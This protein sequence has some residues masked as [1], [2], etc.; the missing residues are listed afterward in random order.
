[1]KK[2]RLFAVAAAMGMFASTVAAAEPVVSTN[3]VA[4]WGSVDEIIKVDVGDK[5]VAPAATVKVIKE[6]RTTDA[7]EAGSID[8]LGMDVDEECE[9]DDNG[10]GYTD[11]QVYFNGTEPG[12][13]ATKLAAIEEYLVDN[14]LVLAPNAAEVEEQYYAKYD[15]KFFAD[16]E[17]VYAYLEEKGLIESVYDE[18]GELTNI[19]I[20]QIEVTDKKGNVLSNARYNYTVGNTR[21]ADEDAMIAV[22]DALVDGKTIGKAEELKNYTKKAKENKLG[23]YY[24]DSKD[25]VQPI[26][27]GS[28]V[29]VSDYKGDLVVEKVFAP[30]DG[31][32]E[33][34]ATG[35][36]HAG[37]EGTTATVKGT[38]DKVTVYETD[39]YKEVTKVATLSQST[40]AQYS[41]FAKMIWDE[42]VGSFVKTTD[43]YSAV[44]EEVKGYWYANE[45]E[46][47]Y[48]EDGEKESETK[49]KTFTAADLAINVPAFGLEEV[50]FLPENTSGKYV[51]QV[52]SVAG[53]NEKESKITLTNTNG[54]EIVVDAVEVDD[55]LYPA[56]D[57]MEELVKVASKLPEYA[58]LGTKFG[59]TNKVEGIAKD[60]GTVKSADYVTWY[61][62]TKALNDNPWS[63]YS[64]DYLPKSEL[65]GPASEACTYVIEE[66]SVEVDAVI[67][68]DAD[69]VDTS[70][71]GVK[72][73]TLTAKVGEE[74]VSTKEVKVVV[75][76]KYERT[77]V[78][79][80]V[81]VLKAFHLNGNL[82]AEYH[83]DWAAKTYSATFYQQDGVTVGSTANG[84]L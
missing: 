42:E 75:A 58:D 38:E 50:E 83:Y 31:E 45:Y 48:D 16:W 77:Y 29:I 28:V 66:E 69:A 9:A 6:T 14:H 74:V 68:S 73:L 27:L 64:V 56:F 39:K 22:V 3:Y 12:Y 1:M 18:D 34:V 11:V 51:L 76:P 47:E 13:Y 78:N 8:N 44:S 62:A 59:D 65:R 20:N 37:W 82:Y 36:T 79:G 60:A 57:T 23:F 52:G 46:V 25:K 2:V 24:V 63:G 10:D 15:N 4:T 72:T 67:S 7:D 43:A 81:S 5:V 32:T 19:Y 49:E 26:A 41:P 55:Q 84:T 35:Y 61:D 71:A 40:A 30:K 17:E 80:K 21:H 54:R 53:V 70:V 33:A